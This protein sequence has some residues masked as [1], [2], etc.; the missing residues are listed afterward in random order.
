ME[1]SED[2]ED[3][4]VDLAAVAG[5][6]P[7]AA[8]VVVV[9]APSGMTKVPSAPPADDEDQD[10]PDL[11]DDDQVQGSLPHTFLCQASSTL[12][13][14]NFPIP[15]LHLTY[16]LMTPA[17]G[18]FF[19]RKV[20]KV[21]N[22]VLVTLPDNVQPEPSNF[23]PAGTANERRG[24]TTDGAS[25]G[26]GNSWRHHQPT[27]AGPQRHQHRQPAGRKCWFVHRKIYK[28]T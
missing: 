19:I 18:Q 11:P 15:K 6:A 13:Q 3:E 26:S 23:A 24:Q 21:K 2:L 22:I 7:A 25:G 20:H 8:A 28:H 17:G 27:A 14:E 4:E 10:P 12:F 9:A 1:P 5:A 16:R